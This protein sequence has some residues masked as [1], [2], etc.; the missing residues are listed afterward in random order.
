M[1]L[2]QRYCLLLV[3]IVALSLTNIAG[4]VGAC[5]GDGPLL[6]GKDRK[7][8]W[9]DTNAILKSASHCVAPQMPTL[10]HQVRIDGYVVIDILVDRKGKVACAE[11]ITGHPLLAGSAIHA[12]KDWTFLPR[13]QNGKDVSFYGHLRFHFS[14]GQTVK[15]ENPCVVAHW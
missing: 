8:I 1:T 3:L 13:K 9:P 15:S 4:S 12:A 11:L 2:T 7:P 5:R 10:A 6:T 14:T